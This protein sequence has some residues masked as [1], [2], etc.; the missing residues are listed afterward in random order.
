LPEIF[1]SVFPRARF[2]N[3]VTSGGESRAEDSTNL[4]LIVYN[5]YPAEAHDVMLLPQ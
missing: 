5:Q 2:M 1:E 3:F 4:W